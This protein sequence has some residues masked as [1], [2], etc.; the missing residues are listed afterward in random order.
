MLFSKKPINFR[1]L[2]QPMMFIIERLTDD[3][4]Q[5]LSKKPPLNY[6]SNP[7]FLG[8]KLSWNTLCRIIQFESDIQLEEIILILLEKNLEFLKI[9]SPS[10]E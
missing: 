7:S 1:P 6:L 2:I 4:T 10:Q 3:H 5:S 8:F 9:S